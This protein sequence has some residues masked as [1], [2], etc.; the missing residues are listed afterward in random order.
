[1]YIPVHTYVCMCVCVCVCVHNSSIVRMA[2]TH[3]YVWCDAFMCV[4]YTH[5]YIWGQDTFI[6]EFKW[7]IHLNVSVI[8]MNVSYECCTSWNIRMWMFRNTKHETTI[9]IH[10]NVDTHVVTRNFN[11]RMFHDMLHSY[12][13]HIFDTWKF[14]VITCVSTFIWMFRVITCA[15]VCWCSSRIRATW[16]YT[17]NTYIYIYIY[18]RAFAMP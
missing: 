17:N 1:M 9:H 11:I 14:R 12:E 13:T 18:L 5:T 8:Y 6:T 3:V 2:W 4:T 16:K 10:M 15:C 7:V